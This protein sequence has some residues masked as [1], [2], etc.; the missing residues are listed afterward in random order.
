MIL[1]VKNLSKTY[2]NKKRHIKVLEDIDFK[3]SISK[4]YCISGNSG[5]GKSTLIQ[6]LGLLLNPTKGTII[7]GGKDVSRL[8]EN[9][10]STIRN[11]KIGFIF[12]SYYLNPLMKAY[13]NVMLPMYINKKYQNNDERKDKSYSLLES[14]GLKERI[15]HYP[16]ELSGG[17]QQRVSIA[18]ALANDPE[19]I[20]ADE[21]TGSL[22]SEN[23]I[24]VLKILRDLANKGK[25]VIVVSHN[26][27]T[28]KYADVNLIIENNKLIEVARVEK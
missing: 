20:L 7:L 9:E 11:E 14:V 28:K 12:Q 6:I 22:D 2:I 8:T 17:E 26:D 10:K 19:I 24:K 15:N 5:A 1:E 23:E 25:C 3:F 27:N 21:P 16:K 18:R 13:E 4:F